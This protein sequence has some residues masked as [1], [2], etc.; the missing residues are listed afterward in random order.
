MQWSKLSALLCLA[1]LALASCDGGAGGSFGMA[2]AGPGA[3]QSATHKSTGKATIVI[4]I[5]RAKR[6]EGRAHYVSAATHSI[7]ITFT[8]SLGSTKTYNRNLTPATNPSCT[9]SPVVCTLQFF[10]GAGKYTAAFATYDGL[11]DARGKPT[12]NELSANQQ[13]TFT[14]VQGRSTP[15]RVTLG[16]IPASVALVPNASSTLI[17]NATQG[18]TLERC[19]AKAQSVNVFAVDAD[20]N[21]ILG[22]GAPTLSLRSSSTL[23]PVTP[24]KQ[25][26]P[27]TFIL[28]PPAPPVYAFP[29][30]TAFLTASATPSSQSGGFA[31]SLSTKITYSSDICGVFTEYPVPTVSSQPRGITVGPDGAIWFTEKTANKLGR[32][33][34]TATVAN[35]QITEFT[36]PTI[37]S[38]PDQITTGPDG[39]L[40]FTECYRG[41]IGRA[42]A[43]GSPIQEFPTPSSSSSP[44]GITTGS[45]G[46]M[47]F[48]ELKGNAI[49]RIPPSGTITITE[50][51]VPTASSGPTGIASGADGALWFTE[52]AGNQ[53]GRIPTVGA[54]ITEYP[55][56]PGSSF[57][58]GI[59][60][61]PDF[62]MW[63][64]ECAGQNVGNIPTNGTG[65]TEFSSPGWPLGITVGP[66]GALWYAM[67]AGVT[68]GRVTTDGSVT[69]FSVPTAHSQP[70]YIV[71]GPDGALWFT[72]SLGNKIGRLQ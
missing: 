63:F 11:L 57:P 15:V 33:P 59:T 26:A 19:N 24:P 7:A 1:G 21:Y 14:L 41:K 55:V 5:P 53:I 40:W 43:S 9:P 12:G 16:G 64:T 68:I 3:A 2:P 49:G 13:V 20:G 50:F 38:G 62:R 22:A 58:R 6:H 8:Q 39:A 47:W 10:M 34:T 71:L 28:T 23:L 25:N 60:S 54:P 48:T 42:P 35:P 66:D 31:A 46:A 61:G 56:A 29:G 37:N 70:A 18:Y 45:D 36:V 69:T 32:I 4:A 67:T 72:E 52:A 44:R 65:S 30:N 27:N 51:P 17:G